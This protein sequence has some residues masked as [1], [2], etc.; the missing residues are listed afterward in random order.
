[1][2][3]TGNSVDDRLKDDG[4]P[5]HLSSSY[6][7]GHLNL[8]S[9]GNESLSLWCVQKGTLLLIKKKKK[10]IFLGPERTAVQALPPNIPT[11]LDYSFHLDAS[12]PS[13]AEYG[14]RT[15]ETLMNFLFIFLPHL[16]EIGRDFQK[17]LHLE[18]HH[19]GNLRR[20]E[21]GKQH[22]KYRNL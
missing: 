2:D 7:W 9:H 12:P 10:S 20:R 18:E 14:E 16:A 8:C 5:W 1:M 13:E 6:L 22:W 19:P 3:L 17:E 11:G 15:G 21:G 4:N